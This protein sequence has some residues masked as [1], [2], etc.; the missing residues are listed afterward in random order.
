MSRRACML[1]F[2]GDADDGEA[3]AKNKA[4]RARPSLVQPSDFSLGGR[5]LQFATKTAER[6]AMCSA[7]AA[8]LSR[9]GGSTTISRYNRA[10]YM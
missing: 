10:T 7:V 8:E 3:G 9:F 1:G 5:H 4:S 2:G 6:I